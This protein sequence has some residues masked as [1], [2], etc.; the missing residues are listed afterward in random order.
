MHHKYPVHMFVRAVVFTADLI[1]DDKYPVH[2]FVRRARSFFT[3]WQQYINSPVNRDMV[4]ESSLFDFS[5]TT[6]SDVV[7]SNQHDEYDKSPLCISE[8]TFVWTI[9]HM[10]HIYPPLHWCVFSMCLVR[11]DF[12]DKD[13]WHTWHNYGN[14]T[15]RISMYFVRWDLCEKDS[16]HVYSTSQVYVPMYLVRWD[17]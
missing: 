12:C 17:K 16:W 3:P 1:K 15:E 2:I 4:Q 9:S 8:M 10:H 7:L 14:S 5:Q 13:L 11:Y 6:H